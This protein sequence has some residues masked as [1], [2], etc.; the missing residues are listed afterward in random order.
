MKKSVASLTAKKSGEVCSA[1]TKRGEVSSHHADIGFRV[2]HAM[3]TV[4]RHSHTHTDLEINF[5]LE[6][7]M[8]YFIAGR[9]HTVKSGS[10]VVFWAGMPHELTRVE[11]HTECVWA[12]IPL[13][14]FL[15]WQLYEAFTQRLLQGELVREQDGGDVGFDRALFLGWAND[16]LTPSL[17]T[18]KIVMLEV[19]ARLRRIAMKNPMTPEQLAAK[20]KTASLPGTATSTQVEILA[21]YI[22]KNYREEISV[23]HIARAVGLH[24]NY[25]MTVFKQGCGMS[26]W[27]YL[28][29]LRVSHAQRL[30]LTTNLKTGQIARESGF[31]SMSRFYETFARYCGQTP[32][33]FR[34]LIVM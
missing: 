10:L 28:L 21:R 16:L 24:P 20:K 25:A 3:P 13:T 23:G 15:Q 34:S 7:A 26:L 18:Q 12:V 6:G 9:F 32:R 1:K 29:R 11:G 19:E 30:L 2:W 14:W 22:S 17:D 33:E 27:E 31:A 8:E 4:M 5:V